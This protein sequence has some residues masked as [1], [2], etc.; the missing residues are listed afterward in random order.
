MDDNVVTKTRE[1]VSKINIEW[2]GLKSVGIYPQWI[3]DLYHAGFTNVESF[4]FDTIVSFTHDE[5]KGKMRTDESIGGSLK[6]E[7]IKDF[8][9]ALS[10]LLEKEFD[11]K[12]LNIPYRMFTVICEK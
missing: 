6:Q 3:T 8:D 10:T 12:T 4:S 1:L 9:L 5:W 7:K 2:R 11:Q